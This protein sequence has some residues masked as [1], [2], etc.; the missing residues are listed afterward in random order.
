[1]LTVKQIEAAKP[2]AKSYRLADYVFSLPQ[3]GKKYG[4]CVTGLTE[5]HKL[6]SLD[7]TPPFLWLKLG[8]SRLRQ[9]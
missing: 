9:N 7:T 6:S 4:A 8:Q 2:E 3:P 5:K 1:M